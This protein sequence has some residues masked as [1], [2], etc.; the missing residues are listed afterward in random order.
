MQRRKFIASA[1]LMEI[2]PYLS[3]AGETKKSEGQVPVGTK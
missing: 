1:L 2:L 3:L